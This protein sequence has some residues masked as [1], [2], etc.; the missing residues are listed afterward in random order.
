MP[1]S[2]K[3]LSQED[4][5]CLHRRE[6]AQTM[7]VA[8]LE[9]TLIPAGRKVY[10]EIHKHQHYQCLCRATAMT[11]VLLISEYYQTGTGKYVSDG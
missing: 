7:R 2:C 4:L 11:T 10:T 5:P 6:L 8:N 3:E 9:L 1:L